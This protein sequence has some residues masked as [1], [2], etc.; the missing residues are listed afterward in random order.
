[1]K[2]KIV[3][4]SFHAHAHTRT[5][6]QEQT[7]QSAHTHTLKNAKPKTQKD[8]PEETRQWLMLGSLLFT[9]EK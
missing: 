8:E 6:T 5:L 9:E 3:F 1:M 4:W 2:P 7:H